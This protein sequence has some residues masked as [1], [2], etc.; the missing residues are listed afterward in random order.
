[1]TIDLFGGRGP[2]KGTGMWPFVF[3]RPW[4]LTPAPGVAVLIDPVSVSS[5][6]AR[7]L[8]KAGWPGMGLMN[9]EFQMA[10]LEEGAEVAAMAERWFEEH[11]GEVAAEIK[12]RADGYGIGRVSKSI[13]VALIQA[14]TA[15]CAGHHLAT[16]RLLMPE[17][18]GIARTMVTDRAQRTSQ[19]AAVQ[20]LKQLLRETPLIKE[21]PVETMSLY[22]FIDDQL[23]AACHTEADAQAFGS[24][25]N[26]H[27]E[28]HA[29][30]SYGTLQGASLMLCATDLL[31]RFACRLLDLGHQPPSGVRS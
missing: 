30:E 28:L 7:E 23:F 17:V 4:D 24:V 5:E 29:L 1:M 12:R 9:D 27:A 31:L 25:P 26:R 14:T 18:E 21:E 11:R 10:L 13:E 19:K 3:P 15:Y 8:R 16:V 20:G 2:R 6:A 22:E